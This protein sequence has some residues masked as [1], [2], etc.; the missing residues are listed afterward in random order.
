MSMKLL[1]CDNVAVTVNKEAVIRFSGLVRNLVED[2]EE[3]EDLNEGILIKN[4]NGTDLSKILDWCEHHQADPASQETN[5]PNGPKRKEIGD[6]DRK[7]FE[8]PQET[9]F[10]I[11]LG[12]NFLDM[13][14]LL[15]M[16]CQTVADMIKGKSSE[17]IRSLFNLVDDLTPEE[18]EQIRTE[19][20][21][22][23]DR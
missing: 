14:E 13:T 16:G 17:E 19:N 4:I 9:L 12:A 8:V 1:S 20:E 22:A 23:E 18:K 2:L 6:W 15:D 7:F 11:I 10:G 21:W 5:E 3:E